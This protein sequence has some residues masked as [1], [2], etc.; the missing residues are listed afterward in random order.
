MMKDLS[1]LKQLVLEAIALKDAL[2]TKRK[3]LQT[4][5]NSVIETEVNLESVQG[6]LVTEGKR[7]VPETVGHRLLVIDNVS[8]ILRLWGP[9][10]GQVHRVE[11]EGVK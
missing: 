7:E 8:Y 5:Q 4:A 3:T 9:E 6:R 1:R 11:V 2:V 10:A